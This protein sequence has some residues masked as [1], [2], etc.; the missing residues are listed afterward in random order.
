MILFLPIYDKHDDFDFEIVNSPFL[1]GDVPRKHLIEFMFLNYS[2]Q[3]D[4]LLMLQTL[5]SQKTFN[6][7][8]S[9]SREST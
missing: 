7:E 2:H 9:Q 1:Y 5:H 4:H 8:T 3:L 6:S